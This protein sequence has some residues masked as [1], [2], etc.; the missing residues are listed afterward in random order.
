MIRICPNGSAD[1]AMPATSRI[2]T[3][4]VRPGVAIRDNDL[5]YIA[6]GYYS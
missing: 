1:L 4:A 6:A 3:A 2:Q 5:A